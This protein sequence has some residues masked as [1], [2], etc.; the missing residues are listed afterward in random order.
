M[1]LSKLG[2]V[3]LTTNQ[4]NLTLPLTNG[5]PLIVNFWATWCPPCREELPEFGKLDSRTVQVL[6][7]ST[8]AQ[9]WRAVTPFLRQHRINIPV[10]LS[11]RTILR[12]FGFRSNP[13][14]LPHTLI[15]DSQGHLRH[16]LKT[17]LTARELTRLLLW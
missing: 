11:N 13:L 3:S 2:P 17:A 9:G 1:P 14:P 5:K 12:A 8:D 16:H 15:Y 10:A 7:I 4:G 6:A